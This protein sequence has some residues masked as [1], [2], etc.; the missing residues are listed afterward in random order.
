[1]GIIVKHDSNFAVVLILLII[2]S[3]GKCYA[4]CCNSVNVDVLQ[5]EF[6]PSE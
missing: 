5:F 6:V 1:M 3:N 2:S 4:Q